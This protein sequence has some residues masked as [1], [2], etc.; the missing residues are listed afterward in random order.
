MRFMEDI[1]AKDSAELDH[2]LRAIDISVPS[3]RTEGRMSEHCEQWSICRWLSTLNGSSDLFFPLR[4]TK[5]QKP[6][7]QICTGKESWGVEVTEAIPTD[8]SRAMAIAER[9]Y[10]NALIDISLFKYGE[11][12]T[13]DEIR[14]ILSQKKLTGD[15]WAG[16]SP[17]RELAEAIRSVTASKTAKLRKQAFDKYPRNVLLIYNNMPLPHLNHDTVAVHCIDKLKDYWFDGLCF[18][19]ILLELGDTILQISSNGLQKLRI[20]DVWRDA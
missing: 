16:D 15:G 19:F 3:C 2:V 7:F 14:Q 1:I 10:P 13:L 9:E 6:D 18:D 20:N 5:R 17:E 11:T 8:F 4:V 12:K